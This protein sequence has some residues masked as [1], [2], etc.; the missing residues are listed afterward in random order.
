MPLSA[1]AILDEFGSKTSNAR[2]EFIARLLEKVV[3][4]EKF[5]VEKAKTNPE[6][7]YIV[8]RW[9]EWCAPDSVYDDRGDRHMPQGCR[10]DM[11]IEYQDAADR[12]GF[13]L[14]GELD[15]S[16]LPGRPGESMENR[17]KM[18]IMRWRQVF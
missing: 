1:W 9:S 4:E 12:R 5:F 13:G 2:G 18:K 7:N 8:E 10:D 6:F 14:A 11:Y 17:K 16:D 15:W 3:G